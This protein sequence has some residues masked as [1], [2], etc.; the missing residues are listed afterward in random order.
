M[1]ITS[2]DNPKIKLCMKLAGSKKARQESGL[3]LAEGARLCSDAISEWQAGKMDICAVFASETALEKYGDYIS[4]ELFRNEKSDIFFT[5]DDN[6]CRKISDT[7]ASQGIFVVAKSRYNT[8]SDDCIK[9][10]GKYLI[11]NNV[12]DP[13][14]LGTLLRTGD[15]VGID[16]VVLT[17]NC[18]ELYNP[19]VLRSAMGSVFRINVYCENDYS[20][21]IDM[22]KKQGIKTWAAVVEK[23][24]VSLAKAD[25]S[26]GGAV[27][28][29]NEGNGLSESDASLC[30]E[31]VTIKMHGNINSLNAAMAGG[32]ILWEMTRS[33]DL[34]E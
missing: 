2:K 32:I 5:V 6:L 9:S 13:G 4:A 18:C 30:D 11:L 33:G 23:D 14:N 12:Q 15:A 3:F 19:K 7:K 21:V 17:N 1:H 29:G 24:A 20:K 16:G 34:N 10:N 26:E 27:V 22:F 28:V 31:R 8:L 25:F